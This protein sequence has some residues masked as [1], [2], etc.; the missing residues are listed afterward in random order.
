MEQL[1]IKE[2][3]EKFSD[4]IDNRN[5]SLYRKI[6]EE[7]GL[8]GKFND[9]N[10]FYLSV[11]YPFENFVE[12]FIKSE[13]SNNPDVVF[14]LKESQFVERHFNKIIKEK[15]GYPCSSDKSRTI[16]HRLIKFYTDGTEISFNYDGVYTYHLP[17]EVF[18]THDEI[19][20][21]YKAL[22]QLYYGNNE[23]YLEYMKG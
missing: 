8:E 9:Y 12:A 13:V 5:M 16:M 3:L 23:W 10:S 6:I 17:K 4:N 14:L 22:K 1:D 19:V 21:S 15:E 20:G 18:T 7:S 2:F 11:I